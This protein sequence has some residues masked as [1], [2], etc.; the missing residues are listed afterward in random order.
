MHKDFS[1]DQLSDSETRRC[2]LLHCGPLA[3]SGSLWTLTDRI[4]GAGLLGL[5]NASTSANTRRPPFD[6]ITICFHWAT[7]LIVLAMFAS[8]WLRSQSHDDVFKALLLQIHRSLGVTIW[9]ATALRLAWRLTNAKLPPF[10][11]NMAKVHRT[12][13][14]LS[15]YGLYALLLGQPATGLGATLLNGRPFALFLWQIPQLMLEDKA[16]RATFHL[17]HELGAW[18]LGVLAAGHAAAALIHHFVLRD[19]VLEC[20]APMIST[21]QNKQES[22]PG[23]VIPEENIDVQ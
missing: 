16:L 23:R 11:V 9:I 21:A 1:L 19:D 8:A 2:G 10:P 13:V 7:V 5:R 17:V 6:N 14:K 18:T 20:M 15:E 4:S 22:L 12:V 3:G